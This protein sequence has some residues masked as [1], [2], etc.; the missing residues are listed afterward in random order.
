[1]SREE[2]AQYFTN[3][4]KDIERIIEYIKNNPNQEPNVYEI[5]DYNLRIAELLG[6]YGPFV[7]SGDLYDQKDIVGSLDGIADIEELRDIEHHPF[8]KIEEVK[9]MMDRVHRSITNM[10]YDTPATEEEKSSKREMICKSMSIAYF[11]WQQEQKKS[12]F[13]YTNRDEFYTL[14]RMIADYKKAGN[15]EFVDELDKLFAVISEKYFASL[16]EPQTEADL[17]AEGQALQARLR[18]INAWIRENPNTDVNVYEMM[19]CHVSV[20]ELLS[21]FGPLIQGRDLYHIPEISGCIN[22]LSEMYMLRRDKL[23]AF[24][25]TNEP[26]RALFDKVTASINKMDY[27]VFANPVAR[28]AK[29]EML[30]KS[31]SIPFYIYQEERKNPFYQYD[32]ESEYQAVRQLQEDYIATGT[33]QFTPEIE[34]LSKNLAEKAPKTEQNSEALSSA[35]K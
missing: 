4:N 1:M 14:Q 24:L 13:P 6:Q 3:L 8:F 34:A 7:N 17:L 10:S 25:N 5:V 26:A 12:P 32:N 15:V 19:D 35:R 29:K 23:N 21:Q 11:I 28:D 2:M 9:S 33:R 30:C 22:E 18:N 31:V 27:E 20:A 16:K